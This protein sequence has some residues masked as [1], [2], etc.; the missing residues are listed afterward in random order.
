MVDGITI[1]HTHQ[2]TAGAQSA[3]L[4]SRVLSHAL[5]L[6]TDRDSACIVTVST[7]GYFFA[8]V[9]ETTL[10]FPTFPNECWTKVRSPSR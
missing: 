8:T 1:G 6:R 3:F 10:V 4:S 7:Y 5:S 9:H 2:G